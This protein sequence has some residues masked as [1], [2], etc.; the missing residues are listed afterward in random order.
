MQYNTTYK[1]NHDL[2]IALK[3]LQ[4]YS[5]NY[6]LAIKL[7]EKSIR[8]DTIIAYAFFRYIDEI[9]D[10]PA[11]VSSVTDDLNQVKQDWQNMCAGGD[12]TLNDKDIIHAMYMVCV[13]REVPFEYVDSFIDAMIMDTY[14]S[15]YTDYLELEEYMYG[16]ACVVG[17]IMTHIVGAHNKDALY[18]AQKYGE[19]MQLIN[20]VRDV[21][22]DFDK[23][24]RIYIPQEYMD[25]YG[26]TE[27]MFKQK[28][29]NNNI[30]D[31]IIFLINKS[32][33]LLDEGRKGIEMLPE[34]VRLPVALAG[35]IYEYNL[36]IVEKRNYNIFGKP[37]RVS[38]CT[39]FLIFIKTILN[40][41]TKR[42][43][44]S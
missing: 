44:Y 18:Y 38:Q 42:K 8:E 19:A 31:L 28:I 11:T 16:S 22:E 30:K 12:F 15:R 3:F 2:Q 9:V 6:A 14:K 25:K 40:L 32:R 35:N 39:K 37:V 21:Q 5:T 17:L 20:F 27:A 43:L 41:W 1:N 29:M 36:Q 4:K 13:R 24:N 34:S 10:N 26:V 7:F 33:Q 23:R